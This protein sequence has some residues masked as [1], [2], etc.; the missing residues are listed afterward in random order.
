MS[1]PSTAPTRGRRLRRSALGAAL[2]AL[3][4]SSLQTAPVQADDPGQPVD[5]ATPAIQALN[6][7][8][9]G[10]FNSDIVGQTSKVLGGDGETYWLTNHLRSDLVPTTALQDLGLG[11][12]IPNLGLG[13]GS[14]GGGVPDDGKRHEYLVVWAG[15]NNVLDRT[16]K[17]LTNLPDVVTP[18]LLGKGDQI[19]PDFFAVVDATK[20]SASYGKV[21]N[22]VTVG[23]LVEN[24]PH[25][26]Q[27]IWHKGNNIFAGGLFTDVTYVLDTSKLPA[28]ELKHVNLPTD[29]LCGSVPDAYWVTKDGSAYGTY[30]GGPDVPGPC[31]YSDGTTRI[32]NGFAGSPGELV[33]LDE[34]GKTVYE[35]PATPETAETEQRCDNIP[36]LAAAT[37]A[38]PHGIQAR[39]DLDTLVTSDYNEPRNIILNPVQAPSSYLRRPTV[40]TWDISDQ[41][42]PKLKAVSFLPDGP[43]VGKVAHQEEPRAAMETT[44]TNLP[45]HKGA[46][47]ETMQGG[48]IYYAPDITAAKP[49]WREVF[50]LTT[51]NKQADPSRNPYGG[52]SNGGWLQTS[53]DDK[54]LYHAV[55]GRQ[56]SGT[57]LGSP[58]YILKLDIQD[59][60]A[61]GT[62]TTCNIDTIE[63]TVNGG[64]ESD[65]PA[66]TDILPAPGGPH[67]GALDNLAVGDDGYFHETK[68]VKRIAYS[69]YFVA[70]TG[71]NGDHR[72][73][74]VDVGSDQKLTTDTSFKDETTGD[75]CIDFDR[76]TWPHGDWGPAKPHS[77]LF[78]TADDDIK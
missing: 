60:L 32:G 26:M 17:Q 9:Q 71:L 50:D 5:I 28:L 68:D 7:L 20:G 2:V 62:D 6:A 52:G 35:A 8:V 59:L 39:E 78:V 64:A 4:L 13:G 49:Q 73:C 18:D 48:A 76:E 10:L 3:G 56:P 61:A 25:H 14:A 24:E 46:F 22:T 11:E 30:M 54:Y 40:R 34:N 70:R 33:R 44:V 47:A 16:G 58:S 55:A 53:L 27:Y 38:N 12:A 41:D 36:Q 74:L 72:V 43:R 75:T 67:W 51:S 1:T 69:N 66:V 15:D 77:M 19:G 57:D 63:E 65:C 31:T 23:P 45:S 21:V 42:H 29:T 37:C